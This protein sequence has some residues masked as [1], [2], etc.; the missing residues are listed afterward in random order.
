VIAVPDSRL[1]Q[2]A[3]ECA[4]RVSPASLFNHVMRTYAFGVTAATARGIAFDREL[5]YIAAVLHDLG[6]TELSRG[7]RRFEIEGADAAKELLAREGMRDADIDLVWDA[8]ALHTTVGVPPRK[9][10]EI[11][12]V[13][14]GAA[15]D[16]GFAPLDAVAAA[17][18]GILE[19]W[20]RLQLKT[21]MM[22]YMERVYE[23]NPAAALQSPVV[24]DVIERRLGVRAPNACDVIERAAFA[25]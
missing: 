5:F 1:C 14:L 17:L 6:L 3:T 25:E 23:R 24:A 18:P 10:P 19:A 12:L 8:I 13:Q 21:E 7:E 15:I 16:V 11:A 2:A 9:R 4:R 22:G 20:P